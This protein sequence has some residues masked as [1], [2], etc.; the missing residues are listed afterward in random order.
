MNLMEELKSSIVNT[1]P[2]ASKQLTEKAISEGYD[3]K[4][5]LDEALIPGMDEVGRLFKEGDYFVPE[6][7]VAAKAMHASMDIIEPLLIKGGVKK[8]GRVVAGT[9]EGDLHDIGKNLVCMM[10]KG[11]GFDVIDL[12]VDVRPE[13]FVKAVKEKHPDFLVISALLTSTMI[14]MPNVITALENDELRDKVKVIVGGAPVSESYAQE[15]G[16][17]G[18]S[19]DSTGAVELLRKL[20]KQ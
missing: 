8:V 20:V 14:N 2:G 6:V 17:D 7:L 12:G 18:Y 9:I 16:A 5:I 15:I 3:A 4:K 19:E 10:L 13:T 11:A 1:N